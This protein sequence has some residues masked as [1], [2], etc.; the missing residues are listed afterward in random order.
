[1]CVFQSRQEHCNE[2]DRALYRGSYKQDMTQHVMGRKCRCCCMS[3]RPAA[4]LMLNQAALLHQATQKICAHGDRHQ[5]QCN[6]C[7][8][9]LKVLCDHLQCDLEDCF[10]DS[11]HL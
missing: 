9:Y 4:Y 6:E 8:A 5:L 11:G 3:H 1:M 2:L 7:Q 10:K